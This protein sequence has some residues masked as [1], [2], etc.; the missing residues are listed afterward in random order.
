MECSTWSEKG[1]CNDGELG[2]NE[3]HWGRKAEELLEG[4]K[5][6]AFVF[7]VQALGLSMYSVAHVQ[8]IVSHWNWKYHAAESIILLLLFAKCQNLRDC[9]MHNNWASRAK[10]C[11]E[12][13]NKERCGQENFKKLSGMCY[14]E[15]SAVQCGQYNE[16]SQKKSINTQVG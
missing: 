13:E 12:L 5:L 10:V 11:L 1:G 8:W 7:C 3:D 6:K 9:G 16:L 2:D 14:F 4:Q 15:D